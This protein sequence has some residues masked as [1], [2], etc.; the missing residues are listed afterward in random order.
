[1]PQHSHARQRR[2][3]L[4][5]NFHR[6]RDA[7]PN[8]VGNKRVPKGMILRKAAEYIHQLNGEGLRLEVRFFVSAHII[9]SISH[10]NVSIDALRFVVS[11]HHTGTDFYRRNCSICVGK[12]S[13]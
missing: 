7:V 2:E 1:M 4:K 13:A 3:G 5:S 11:L 10:T 12:M 8:I 9:L 6:L